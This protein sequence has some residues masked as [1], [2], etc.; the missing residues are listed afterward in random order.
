MT[1]P[2]QSQERLAELAALEDGWLDGSGLAVAADC[3]DRAA[4]FMATDGHLR[5]EQY[6]IFPTEDGGVLLEHFGEELCISIEFYRSGNIDVWAADSA[7]FL[8]RKETLLEVTVD[9]VTDAAEQIGSASSQL[10]G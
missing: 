9:T 4:K 2:I 8:K 7:A 10:T 5:P 6:S 3:L 1:L